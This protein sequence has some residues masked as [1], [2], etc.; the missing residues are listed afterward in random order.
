[1]LLLIAIKDYY[2]TGKT[3]ECGKQLNQCC[4]LRRP[5]FPAR[6]SKWTQRWSS[7]IVESVWH[8][9]RVA[10]TVFAIIIIL[11]IDSYVYSHK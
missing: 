8:R 2:K 11:G 6:M 9:C 7:H 3:V 1:M 4:S 10:S 5:L